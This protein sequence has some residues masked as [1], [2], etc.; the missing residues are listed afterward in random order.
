[1]VTVVFCCCLKFYE[2]TLQNGVSD[3]ERTLQGLDLPWPHPNRPMF[4]LIS[5]GNEEMVLDAAKIM[6]SH[7]SF[8]TGS[9]RHILLEQN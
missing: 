6:N 5:T 9:G 8:V 4:F 2:G 3:A 1:M 7:L